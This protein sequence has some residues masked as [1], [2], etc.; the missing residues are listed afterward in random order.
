MKTKKF[1]ILFA[2]VFAFV[3]LIGLASATITLSSSTSTLPQQSGS[4]EVSVSSNQNETINLS[5]SNIQDSYGKQITFLLSEDKVTITPNETA[6]TISVGYTVE[7]GFHFGLSDSY[8]TTLK[9]LGNVSPEVKKTFSLAASDF[10]EYANQGGLRVIIDDF[11]V[12]KGIGTEKKWY[13]F[14]EIEVKLEIR[15]SGKWDIEDVSVEWGV[16]NPN[17]NKWTIEVDEEDE[18]DLDKGDRETLTLRFALDNTM[19]ED[20][21]DL[22]KGN[23]YFY[24][25]AT[26][27]ISGGDYKGDNTCAS[28]SQKGEFVLDKKLVAISNLKYNSNIQCDSGLYVSGKIWNIGSK[29]QKGVYLTVSNKELGINQNVKIGDLDSFESTGFDFTVNIPED[30]K[31]KT[32]TLVL[33]AYDKD[34]ESF[35]DLNT[36]LITINVEG[37]CGVADA[38]LTAL[39]ESG[40]QAG[41]DLVVKAIVT[42]VGKKSAQYTL[43][44][45]G[46]SS[47]AS[48]I[49]TSTSSLNLKP[50]QSEEVLLTFKVNNDALGTNLFT[51]ELLS[52]SESVL[53][54]PVQVEITKKQSKFFSKEFFLKDG[55]YLWGIGILNIILIAL[56]III[57]IRIARK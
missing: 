43:K 42:N 53:T 40:G 22:V 57:A 1:N 55:K 13:A 54:Q 38:M 8:S 7:S 16:Y 39:L 56:I 29:S 17:T 21:E 33:V 31:E 27:V 48:S 36:D 44:V 14:D 24:V 12:I 11:E 2:S 45:A 51:I 25:R 23:L 50:G 20:L 26:G 4:F 32:Y 19:D 46:Y 10:C 6:H 37:N 5:I 35:K 34:D 52:D 41:N 9:A 3:F 30:A 49:S 28:N 15:N 47:W 18:F